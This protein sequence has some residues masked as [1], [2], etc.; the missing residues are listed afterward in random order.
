MQEF[1]VRDS[2]HTEMYL[3]ISQMDVQQHHT[4]HSAFPPPITDAQCDRTPYGERFTMATRP[5]DFNSNLHQNV[6]ECQIER[7]ETKT[8]AGEGGRPEIQ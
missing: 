6:K 5:V 3:L 2:T 1:V 7:G 8:Q 4:R